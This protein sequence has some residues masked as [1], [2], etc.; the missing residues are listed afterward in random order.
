[1]IEPSIVKNAMDKF[2]VKDFNE[3]AIRQIGGIVKDIEEH[4]G[5]EFVHLEIGVPG[6]PPETI[7]VNAEKAALD[8]GVASIDPEMPGIPSHTE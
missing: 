1:M 2:D 5:T 3:A 4:T 7:G 8:A 6:L